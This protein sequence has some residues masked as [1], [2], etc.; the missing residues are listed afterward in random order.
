M[1]PGATRELGVPE[2][3]QYVGKRPPLP[4][5]LYLLVQPQ[6]RK[7]YYHGPRYETP[8]EAV[9]VGGGLASIDVVGAPAPE[10]LRTCFLRML[11]VFTPAHA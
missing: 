6:E 10:N 4:K 9:V 5:S 3:E 11:A 2:A 1:A 7:R 8:D